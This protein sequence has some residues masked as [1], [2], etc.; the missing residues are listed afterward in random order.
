MATHPSILAWRIPMDSG[1]W[2]A[3]A[4]GVSELGETAAKHSMYLV[5]GA[6][7]QNLTQGYKATILQIKIKVFLNSLRVSQ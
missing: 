2:P 4:H 1:A 5:H 6:V 7:Q 3:T